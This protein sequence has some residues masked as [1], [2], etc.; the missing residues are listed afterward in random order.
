MQLIDLSVSSAQSAVILLPTMARESNTIFTRPSP[1]NRVRICKHRAFTLVELLV[2]IGIIALLISILLPTLSK[3]QRTAQQTKCLSNVR[4]IGQGFIQYENDNHGYFP[5]AA[6]D[7]GP[8]QPGDWLWWQSDRIANLA[9]GGIAKYLNITKDAQRILQCPADPLQYRPHSS[10]EGAY[11]FSYTLN[12][13]FRSVDVTN[14]NFPKHQGVEK[15]TAVAL[16]SEKVLIIEED[17]STVDDGYA[18]IYPFPPAATGVPSTTAQTNLLAIR[19]DRS[20]KPQPDTI[21]NTN[22]VPN[23][24]L[25][26]NV[27]FCDGHAEFV[28]RD[29]AHSAYHTVPNRAV[30]PWSTYQEIPLP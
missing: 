26:G 23:G 5:Y 19:H 9:T 13:F 12:G 16:S 1:A 24:Q 20:H 7:T 18:T 21:T 11:P 4:Q 3:V 29:Y 25:K 22:P 30:Y 10:A 14:T 15:I 28:N 27:G 2:V 17:E 6:I 8:E